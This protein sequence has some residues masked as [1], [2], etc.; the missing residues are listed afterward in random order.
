MLVSQPDAVL[1]L[2]TQSSPPRFTTGAPAAHAEL[3][4]RLTADT[5]HDVWLGKMRLR[6]AVMTGAIKLDGSPLR[7]LGLVGSLTDLFRFV[8]GIYPDVLRERGLGRGLHF[9][10]ET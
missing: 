4:L 3:G 8:E 7:A 6:D 5:L 9:S 2:D 10:A 1:V